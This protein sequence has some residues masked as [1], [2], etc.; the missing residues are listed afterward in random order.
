MIRHIRG[1]SNKRIPYS[2][3][4]YYKPYIFKIYFKI[5][6]IWNVAPFNKNVAQEKSSKINKRSPTFIP[7][8]KVRKKP[9]KSSVIAISEFY[10]H[11]VTDSK[12]FSNQM[13]VKPHAG[14]RK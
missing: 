7:E 5:E 8:S 3:T 10:Y 13:W 12:N 9:W 1:H 4:I 6:K 11:P 14:I 2:N